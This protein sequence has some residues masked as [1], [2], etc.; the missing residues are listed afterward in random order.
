MLCREPQSTARREVADLRTDLRFP[1][2]R[3]EL[4]DSNLRVRSIMLRSFDVYPRISLAQDALRM[5]KICTAEVDCA[6]ADMV[7]A[8]ERTEEIV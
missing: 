1:R 8:S 7:G 2:L 3:W 4:R 5:T 6:E